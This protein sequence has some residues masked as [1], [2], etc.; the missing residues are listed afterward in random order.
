MWL[1][2]TLG[3]TSKERGTATSLRLDGSTAQGSASARPER[4]TRRSCARRPRQ[5]RPRLMRNGARRR[6]SAAPA[7]RMG[8][9]P[10]WSAIAHYDRRRLLLGGPPRN[11]RKPRIAE[12]PPPLPPQPADAKSVRLWR[13]KPLSCDRPRIGR[14]GN[15]GAVSSPG[16]SLFGAHPVCRAIP[17]STL[18]PALPKATSF[19]RALSCNIPRCFIT[20][21][22]LPA[23]PK[24]VHGKAHPPPVRHCSMRGGHHP[25][26]K[27]HFL[28]PTSPAWAIQS[29]RTSQAGIRRR[30][31]CLNSRSNDTPRSTWNS[32]AHR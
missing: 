5:N 32:L 26:W 27:S 8:T 30:R 4:C 21:K 2:F 29:L 20:R 19:C 24:Q 18:R 12:P 1:P 10:A 9:N 7:R 17:I 16:R 14:H 23:S 11:A 28:R 15:R 13:H 6:P 3:Q 31:H 25:A 22:L